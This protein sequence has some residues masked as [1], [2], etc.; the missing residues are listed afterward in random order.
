MPPSIASPTRCHPATGAAADSAA[1]RTTNAS[2]LRLP[3]AYGRSLVR[4]VCVLRGNGLLSE[5]RR[6]RAAG[7]QE[8]A[9][10]RDALALPAGEVDPALA[11]ERVV[12]VRQLV[13]ED[14]DAGRV[15]R[16]QHVLPGRIRPRRKEVLAQRY[17]EEDGLLSHERH[18]AP[19]LGEVGRPCLDAA[20]EH[21]ARGRVVEAGKE[22]EQRRLAGARRAADGDDLARSDGEVDAAQH[23]RAA[24]VGE[25]DGRE[26]DRERPPRQRLRLRGDGEGFDAVEPGEAAPG[27][28]HRALAQVDDP[29]E[30]LE[31]PHELEQQRDEEAELSDRELSGDD[32][33]AAEEE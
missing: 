6:E 29:A 5:E 14:V 20:H 9:G 21:A 18:G 31:R 28:C 15:A 24:A 11:D 3:P 32:L 16:G 13:D 26:L 27:G 4:P 8:G 17:G 33:A 22:V 23:L 10:E 12:A 2:T 25:A 7:G 19:Q 30:G 1:S